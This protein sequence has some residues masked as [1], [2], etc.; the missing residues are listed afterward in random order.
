MKLEWRSK[1]QLIDPPKPIGK[2]RLVHDHWVR[3]E[4][5]WVINDWLLTFYEIRLKDKWKVNGETKAQG[6]FTTLISIFRELVPK[7]FFF[8]NLNHFA[9]I[10]F[11][12]FSV[13][14]NNYESIHYKGT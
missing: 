14:S 7:T 8:W 10:Y 13:L 4:L 6:S 5:E 1:D 11:Q 3:V 2:G 9:I 12:T